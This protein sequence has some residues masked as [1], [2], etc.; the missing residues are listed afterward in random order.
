MGTLPPPCWP[1]DAA[2]MP[3]THRWFTFSGGRSTG[4]SSRSAAWPS[5][6]ESIKFFR[7][8]INA[9]WSCR[10]ASKVWRA[11]IRDSIRC[12]ESLP[13]VRKRISLAL[14]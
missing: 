3:R 1:T 9:M 14:E 7:R 11:R 4:H 8:R 10:W 12:P 5:K 13:H 2:P 6:V